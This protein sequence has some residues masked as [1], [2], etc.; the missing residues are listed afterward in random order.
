[1]TPVPNNSVPDSNNTT[2][3]INS[4]LIEIDGPVDMTRGPRPSYIPLE[5]PRP[6]FPLAP[7]PPV[8]P[9]EPK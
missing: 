8:P 6:Q 3:A 7:T 9:Q 5:T 4:I 1:M 2:E